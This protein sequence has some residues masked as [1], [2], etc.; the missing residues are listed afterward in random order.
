AARLMARSGQGQPASAC[1]GP[2]V[3]AAPARCASAAEGATRNHLPVDAQVPAGLG[4]A[5][6][7]AA[8]RVPSGCPGVSGPVPQPVS[9]DAAQ[10]ARAAGVCQSLHAD[11]A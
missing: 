10:I 7:T 2:E 4:T 11:E 6:G 5:T 9:M 3:P 1:G 8:G